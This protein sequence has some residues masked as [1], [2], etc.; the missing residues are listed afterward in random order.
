MIWG[1]CKVKQQAGAEDAPKGDT[2]L[3]VSWEGSFL[4][5]LFYIYIHH[6]TVRIFLLPAFFFEVK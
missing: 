4:P 5:S 1:G 2:D 6:Q 3:A